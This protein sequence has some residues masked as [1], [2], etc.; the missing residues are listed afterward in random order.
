L[1]FLHNFPLL[2]KRRLNDTDDEPAMII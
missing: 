2:L 1:A